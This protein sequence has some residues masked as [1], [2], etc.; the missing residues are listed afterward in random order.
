M[1]SNNQVLGNIF[2]F[3]ESEKILKEDSKFFLF[4]KFLKESEK[5]IKVC[6]LL[7]NDQF[8]WKIQFL[9]KN[10]KHYTYL[11]KISKNAFKIPFLKWKIKK[12]KIH[13]F[14]KTYKKEFFKFIFTIWVWSENFRAFGKKCFGE[15]SEQTDRRNR[16][17]SAPSNPHPLFLAFHPS[18]FLN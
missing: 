17:L 10:L 16:K 6:S 11:F 1:S 18:I 2:N 13:L 3:R 9:H 15:D 4:R 14:E 7:R 5:V 8:S 12:F